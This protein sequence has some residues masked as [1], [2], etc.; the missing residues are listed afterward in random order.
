MN[1]L[2]IHPAYPNQFTAIAHGMAGIPGMKCAFLTEQGNIPQ[3][4]RDNAPIPYYAYIKD[5]ET[6]KDCW[7]L[8]SY[9]EGLRHGKAVADTLPR[10]METFVPDL[11]IGHGSFGTTLYIKD[12]FGLPVISYV[13]LP[14]YHMAWCRQEFPALLEH[15]ILNTAFQSLVYSACLK[16]DRVIVPS[17]HAGNLFPDELKPKIR[18]RMEG[19]SQIG[20]AHV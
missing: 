14:G 5:G 12:L 18:V 1:V 2:F 7:Y 10:V 9:E 19:F 16:S 17:F 15:K 3:V 11:V 8:T 13:E 4:I 6:G 20:R